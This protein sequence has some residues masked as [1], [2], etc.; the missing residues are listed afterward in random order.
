M[1]S[2]A[3]GQN[4]WWQELCREQQSWQACRSSRSTGEEQCSSGPRDSTTAVEW[5]KIGSKQV[6]GLKESFR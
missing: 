3:R 6:A 4:A 1:N 5:P 2:E